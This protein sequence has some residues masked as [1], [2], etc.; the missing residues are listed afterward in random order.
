MKQ[1]MEKA[2][3]RWAAVALTGAGLAF[4]QCLHPIWIVAWLAPMPALIAMPSARSNREALALALVA[5][6]VAQANMALYYLSGFSQFPMP[7]AVLALLMATFTLPGIIPVAAMLILWRLCARGR[8]HWTL[9][10]IFPAIAAAVDL[11]FA[12]LS[13]NGTLGS[14]A[15]SQMSAL[16]VIQVAALGGTPLIVFV[17]ALVGSSLAVFALFGLTIERP[18]LAYGLPAVLLSGALAFGGARLATIPQRPTIPFGLAATDVIQRAA[19][20][21]DAPGDAAPYLAAAQSLVDRG[22]TFVVLPEVIVHL[23][24]AATEP[25]RTIFSDWAREHHVALLVGVLIDNGGIVGGFSVRGAQKDENRAWLFDRGGLQRAD[26]LKQQLIPLI[27]R[28]LKP[29]HQDS[30]VTMDG[31]TLGVTICRDLDF[32]S[33]AARYVRRG[34]QALLAPSLDLGLDGVW[35]ARMGDLRGVEQGV[36]IIRSADN[37]IMSVSDPYGRIVDQRPSGTA[38]TVATLRVTAPLGAGQTLYGKIG[39]LFGWVCA[40]LI[41]LILSWRVFRAR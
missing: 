11:I 5:G 37:G 15:Y 23:D 31:V 9:P 12:T 3:W 25:A 1:L 19:R 16:P 2:I 24:R 17:I 10:L 21:P 22:A 8:N 13:P 40:G 38:N 20:N 30:V 7:S 41:A 4:V 34:A 36:S 29:G 32:P 18:W 33:L 26:Y 27:N 28:G 35:H 6:L 14:W 39:D